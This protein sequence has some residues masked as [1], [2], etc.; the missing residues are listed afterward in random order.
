MAI[1]I[2]IDGTDYSIPTVGNAGWGSELTAYLLALGN[3]VSSG[4]GGDVATTSTVGTVKLSSASQTP[5][6]PV[7]M[8]DGGGSM[9]SA[10][11]APV[12]TLTGPGSSGVSTLLVSNECADATGTCAAIEGTTIGSG[13]AVRG[14]AAT[15]DEPGSQG[16]VGLEGRGSATGAPARLVPQEVAPTYSDVGALYVDSLG[17]LWICTVAGTTGGDQV[18]TAVGSAASGGTTYTHTSPTDAEYAVAT[19]TVPRG[20]V[21]RLTLTVIANV[22]QEGPTRGEAGGAFSGSLCEVS[23]WH[24]TFGTVQGLG[25]SVVLWNQTAR[26]GVDWNAYMDIVGGVLSVVLVNSSGNMLV[27]WTATV[28]TKVLAALG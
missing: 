10:G 23:T 21:V 4:G 5:L 20:S 24:N 26:P 1:N 12:L 25:S 17:V 27:D 3:A 18:W 16:S 28:E 2:T 7:V 9:I 14:T 8:S 11:S 15:G 13:P 19:V 22:D 6:A